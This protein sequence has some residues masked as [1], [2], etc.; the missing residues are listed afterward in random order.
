MQRNK[1]PRK[2]RWQERQSSLDG[3]LQGP[4][5]Q[6]GVYL[7]ESFPVGSNR[8][9][10]IRSVPLFTGPLLD[11]PTQGSRGYY[12]RNGVVADLGENLRASRMDT[13]GTY[14]MYASLSCQ[15]S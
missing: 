7:Q 15:W 3:L 14:D 9:G 6:E 13:C 5:H 1:R 8:G 10:L 11:R 12:G 2:L 4:C